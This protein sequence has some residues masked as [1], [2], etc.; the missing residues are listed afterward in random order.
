[1]HRGHEAAEI[2][3]TLVDEIRLHSIDGELQ[4]ELIGDLATLL[5]FA[6]EYDPDKKS[7]GRLGDQGRTKMVGCGG[8]QPTLFAPKFCTPVIPN[9]T[10]ARAG[11]V[12]ERTNLELKKAV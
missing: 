4:V 1:M 12:Q 5:G 10:V 8:S 9:L 7:P 11:Y 6:K 3:R 2:L